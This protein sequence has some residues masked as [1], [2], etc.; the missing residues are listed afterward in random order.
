MLP[1]ISKLT[2]RLFVILLLVTLDD[3]AVK[4]PENVLADTTLAPV[5][6]PFE[7][8]VKLP[9]VAVVVT[10][11]VPAIFEPVFVTTNVVT[12]SDVRLIF[13]LAT[14]MYTLL[15]PLANGPI[16]LPPVT[17][18]VTSKLISVPTLVIFG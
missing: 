15:F 1:L 6:L 11:N 9:T 12:P 2:V 16:K 18:P 8:T 3:V 13:P 7:L 17:L 10:F 14:G 4:L 5:I